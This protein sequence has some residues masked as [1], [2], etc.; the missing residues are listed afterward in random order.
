MSISKHLMGKVA[1]INFDEPPP[2]SATVR[3]RSEPRTAPGQTM[4]L[5]AKF[6]QAQEQI[7]SLQAQLN[8]ASSRELPVA[9]LIEVKGRRRKLTGEQYTELRE[10]LRNNP[11]ITPISVRANAS[12]A[13]EIVSGHNRV[14][15]YRELGR[16]TIMAVVIEGDEH[17]ADLG[18]FYA[19]LLQPNLPDYEKYIGFKMVMEKFPALTHEKIAEQAGVSRALVTTIMAFDDLPNEALELLAQKPEKIGA[20]AAL[21]LAS[22]AKRGRAKQVTEAIEK[23]VNGELDQ[24]QAIVFATADSEAKQNKPPVERITIK[25]GKANYC[26]FH[27]TAKVMRLQF[28]SEAEAEAIQAEIVRI[29]E[30]RANSSK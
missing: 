9:D 19:N 22:L 26:E 5:Q 21:K 18:A 24:S 11:L 7:Q 1:D 14:A 6:T 23:V 30:S 27:R 25:A 17:Q 3:D 16:T 28:K 8:T 13:Y 2:A 10:N 12:G 4:M 15:V 29:L 20:A